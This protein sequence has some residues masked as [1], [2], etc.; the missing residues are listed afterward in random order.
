[1]LR[2]L[3]SPARCID[4]T[5]ISAANTCAHKVNQLRLL[6]VVFSDTLSWKSHTAATCKKVCSMLGAL[7]RSTSATNTSTRA[8]LYDVF[9]KPKMNYCLPVWGNSTETDIACMKRIVKR[10][11]RT[12]LNQSEAIFSQESVKSQY[13]FSTSVINA[14]AQC[15]SCTWQHVQ[16]WTMHI[17][18][19]LRASIKQH[20]WFW[21]EQTIIK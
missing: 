9:I 20:S 21:K 18:Y 10:A 19:W 2:K 17:E 3:K 14:L 7:H 5:K 13:R 1:M 6:G 15:A 11:L 12:V 8:R 4:S 16:L